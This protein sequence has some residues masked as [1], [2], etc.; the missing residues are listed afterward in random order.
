MTNIVPLGEYVKIKTGKLDANASSENGIY[1][2]FTCSRNPLKIDNYSYDCECVLVAGNGDLNVKYYNG[3][4]DAYQR[5]YIIEGKNNQIL[6]MRYL[7][8]FMDKYVELLRELSIGGVIKYI[9]LENLTMAKLPLPPLPTQQKIAA[10]L[11]KVSDLITERKRQIEQLD[12]LVK[13][14]FTEMFGDLKNND[15]NWDIV[16]FDYA[17]LIDTRMTNEFENYADDPHIGIE[18]IEKDT[19]SLINYKPVKE[20][21]L[22]SGKYPFDE[23]HIIYSKIRP[24][25]NKVALPDFKGLCSADAYPILPKNNC[26]RLYLVMV[27]RSDLFLDYILGFSG[28]TN[29]PKV[30]KTALSSFNLPLPPLSLQTKFAEFVQG[31]DRVKGEVRRGLERLEML[32]GALMQGYF[33]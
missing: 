10:V 28:R 4:F 16:P 9:K 5:T 7:Y 8:H 27:M 22:I 31:V 11:D 6:D 33:G 32:Y 13:A 20:C 18:N 24:N 1:P 19:G 29:I 15:K 23:R 3:K 14:R 30:N 26:N 2:F 25:L 12:L 21:G 17:A